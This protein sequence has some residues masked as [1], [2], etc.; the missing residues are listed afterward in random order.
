MNLKKI[1]IIGKPNVGKSSLFNRIVGERDAIISE[2]AGTTRDVKIREVLIEDRRAILQDTGGFD[3]T[4]ELFQ[5]V[6]ERALESAEQADIIL[7]MI[8]GRTLPDDEDRKRF[9]RLQKQ[10]K[11]IAL[12][13]NKLDN[14]KL[15]EL[16]WEFSSFGNSKVFSIS[17]SHNRRVGHL[18]NWVYD[19]LVELEKISVLNNPELANQTDMSVFANSSTDEIRV[20]IIGRVNVGKSS[21]LNALTKS[22]RAIV[23]P[24]AGTTIDPIDEVIEVDGKKIR[25]VDTA[26]IRKRGKIEGIEKYA[27]MRTEDML[28]R[29]H[30]AIVVLDS[31][32]DLKDLDEKI[33]GLVDKYKLATI[34]VLNKWDKR[35]KEHK[36]AVKEVRDKFKFLYFA[37]IMTLSALTHQ[38]VHKLY[39]EI[40]RIYENFSRRVSTSQLNKVIAEAVLNH[41]LPAPKGKVIKIYFAVQYSST[42]PKIALI[43]NRPSLLHFSY[44]RYL[45]NQFRESFDFEGSPIILI[46][47]NRKRDGDIEQ[48]ENFYIDIKNISEIVKI[49]DS[50]FDD[51][52]S[53]ELDNDFIDID[54]EKK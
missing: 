26:G 10:N 30:L 29:S 54:F 5:Q 11:N 37:P 13:I 19:R 24:I 23:S 38:R 16:V 17:V 44:H 3:G 8:D 22:E 34:I 25:F 40:F 36:E 6:S 35:S 28:Q 14:D 33:A 43:M 47:K 48:E 31:S 32:E 53:S 45:I 2:I 42:P 20:A 39:N 12:V 1:A 4:S 41:S 7:Y 21:L 49:D 9:F 15:E 27:L 50:D 46:K 18:L 52:D 51:S